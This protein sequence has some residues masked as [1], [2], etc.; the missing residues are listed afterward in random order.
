MKLGG[1]EVVIE[2]IVVTS[3]AHPALPI[4]DA[5]GLDAQLNW[6]F[7]SLRTPANMLIFEVETA[8]EHAMREFWLEH[9]FIEIH[10]PKL[11]HSASESGSETFRLDYFELGTA[12]L[13]QPAEAERPGQSSLRVCRVKAPLMLRIPVNN[14]IVR[15]VSIPD[16]TSKPEN[17]LLVRLVSAPLRASVFVRSSSV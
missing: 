15:F 5:S 4:S 1:L 16:I 10:S 7:L 11:M 8:V 17:T 9:G 13:A 14:L 2:S 12:Y 3:L 6:R